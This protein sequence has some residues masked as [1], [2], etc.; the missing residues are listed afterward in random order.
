MRTARERGAAAV[1]MAIVLPVLIL[2]L[3]GIIDFGRAFYTQVII[4]N[5]AREGARAA[6]VLT[7]GTPNSNIQSRALAGTTALTPAATAT[8]NQNCVGAS[9]S[10]LADVTVSV[11][12]NYFFLSIIPGIPSSTTLSSKGVMACQ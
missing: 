3:G 5:G 4:T 7:T 8:V 11:S 10:T 1:E 6:I 12:F 9:A 2:I